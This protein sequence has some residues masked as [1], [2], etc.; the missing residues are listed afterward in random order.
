MEDKYLSPSE[1][2]KLKAELMNTNTRSNNR[3]KSFDSKRN[4]SRESG[5]QFSNQEKFSDQFY[6]IRND[7]ISEDFEENIRQILEND[8]H[9]KRADL[10]RKFSYREIKVKDEND[11]VYIIK[12]ND[13]LKLNIKNNEIIL[14]LNC[15]NSLDIL[16][17]DEHENL[18]DQN[19][20]VIQK[21]GINLIIGHLVEVEIDGLFK[22]DNFSISDFSSNEISIIYNNVPDIK[23]FKNAA[24]EVKYGPKNFNGL[25]NQLKRDKDVL[26]KL[27]YNSDNEY[28]FIGFIKCKRKQI[29]KKEFNNAI[30]N[31]LNVNCIIIGLNGPIFNEKKI[32]KFYDWNK[33]IND[34]K[35]F[36]L[37]DNKIKESEKRLLQK[38]KKIITKKINKKINNLRKEM[39]D[40]FNK[41]NKKI[42]LLSN[43]M[44]HQNIGNQKYLGR[45]KK[46]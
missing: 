4:R 28:V 5:S 44:L 13:I 26:D 19:E 16:E 2:N 41:I 45:K 27:N 1:I 29:N 34:K 32:N 30:E 17:K 23:N 21:Y 42:D 10:N 6:K 8:Y 39:N 33:I 31:L 35:Q 37:L 38:V 3:N 24:I 20:K 40:N 15:D 25:V 36:E 11:S 14:K 43:M 18:T 7:E 12:T 22:I 9:W 46:R